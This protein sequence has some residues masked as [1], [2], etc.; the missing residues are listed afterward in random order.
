[1]LQSYFIRDESTN[2]KYEQWRSEVASY[3]GSHHY[4]SVMALD[5]KP[6]TPQTLL[7]R[8]YPLNRQ[9]EGEVPLGSQSKASAKN[10]KK[11]KNKQITLDFVF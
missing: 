4:F 2:L 9:R 1:M 5:V 10:N 11:K 6:A 3:A 7:I 8:Q